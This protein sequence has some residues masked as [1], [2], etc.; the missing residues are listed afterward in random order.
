VSLPLDTLSLRVPAPSGFIPDKEIFPLGGT[1]GAGTHHGTT[2]KA[3]EGSPQ[4]VISVPPV[5]GASYGT[6]NPEV[7]LSTMDQQALM[8]AADTVSMAIQSL[9]DIS[10]VSPHPW[11]HFLDAPTPLGGGFFL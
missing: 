11:H 4:S 5:A 2:Q 3:Y 8:K 6:S 7:G 9:N 10:P 1:S